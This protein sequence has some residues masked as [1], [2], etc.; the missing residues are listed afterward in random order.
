MNLGFIYLAILIG[1]YGLIDAY[2]LRRI[3][4]KLDEIKK[5]L[6]I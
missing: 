2:A 3:E 5:H 1:V 4:R 6:N